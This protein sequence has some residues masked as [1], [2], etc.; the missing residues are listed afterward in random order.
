[1]AAGAVA[2]A[3]NLLSTVL[4]AR[5][6]SSVGYGSLNKLVG[7]FLVLSMPGTALMVGVVRR[8]TAWEAHGMGDRVHG[9]VTRIHVVGTAAVVLLAVCIW[10]ARAPIVSV[11]HLPGSTGVVEVISAGGI[12]VLVAL[13]R[14]LLQARRRYRQL[15]VNLVV[16]GVARTAGMIGLTAAGLGLEGAALGLLGGELAAFAHARLAVSR[17]DRPTAVP[18]PDL[19]GA[20]EHVAPGH[21]GRDLVADVVAAT[22]AMALLAALQN[23]DVIVFG[24]RSPGHAGSY[25]A[26]SVPSKALVFVALL[27]GNYLL[28]ETSIRFHQGLHALR[29][30]GHTLVLLALPALSL[31]A[32]A[33]LVPGHF[34]GLVFGSKYEA[35][36]SAFAA[37]VLS[38]ALLCVTVVLTVY[39]LGMGWRW[40]VVPLAAGTTL[41][42]VLC[43]PAGRSIVQTTHA[44]LVVQAVLASAMAGA[45]VLRH[46][47]AARRMRP[48]T[49]AYGLQP[50]GSTTTPA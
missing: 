39:L 4:V 3:S 43:L 5:L 33:V 11:M 46:R 35:G 40:V 49:T 16:E 10:L 17:A 1:M 20:A 23:A 36:A 41:L 22:L 26:I 8:V 37:L 29:Q 12:W 44:D 31:L 21:S 19:P 24:S 13:D 47:S 48:A 7:L 25:A 34:L 9:W 2:G 45:L 28:P 14:G 50:A 27:L 38:M 6:L 30:L 15:S 42:V 18:E 32:L